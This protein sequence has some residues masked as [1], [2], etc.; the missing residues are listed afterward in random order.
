MKRGRSGGPPT[1]TQRDAYRARV[2]REAAAII[3]QDE[4][5]ARARGRRRPMT[6]R[7]GGRPARLRRPTAGRRRDRRGALRPGRRTRRSVG[8]RGRRGVAPGRR[9]TAPGAAR[10]AA[11]SASAGLVRF[12]LFVGVLAAIVLVVALTVLRPVV[13]GAVVDWAADNPSA[14]AA[15]VRRRPRPRGPR[16]GADRPRRA[17][18]PTQVE[19]T[20][21]DGDT[22]AS[23]AGRLAEQRLPER[24]RGPSCSSRPS[25]NLADKL[26]AGT[27][28]LRKNMT[29]DQL[30][31]A[32]LVSKDLAVSVGLREGLRLEQ[33]TAK[34]Q[35][36]PLTMDVR[37]STTW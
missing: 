35:T 6:I 13:A 17:P 11:G 10:A 36:L 26:E 25:E 18:I 21:A 20:V 29:P 3:L 16:H 34:L 7:G 27:Y 1:A 2:D 31:T 14:L 22:A 19:F 4:L 33:I 12:V 15:A 28:I 30:V 9:P 32:L 8:S 23:I 5:D 37:R 24:C